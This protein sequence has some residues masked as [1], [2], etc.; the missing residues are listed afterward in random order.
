MRPEA[1]T[2]VPRASWFTDTPQLG[3][4]ASGN[5]A[6]AGGSPDHA[7]PHAGRSLASWGPAQGRE[8]ASPHPLSAL[9]HG[10]RLCHYLPPPTCRDSGGT[11]GESS[12]VKCPDAGQPSA[13]SQA[14]APGG[15]CRHFHGFRERG[16]LLFSGETSE[17]DCWVL[18]I[19]PRMSKKSLTLRPAVS[20]V[21]CS[22]PTLRSRGA[23][24]E[25]AFWAVLIHMGLK[26][27]HSGILTL[28]PTD[29]ALDLG[30]GKIT[31]GLSPVCHLS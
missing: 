8:T 2:R 25:T 28:S 11:R 23:V 22:G 3:E 9:T 13:S 10:Q 19:T 29:L 26:V 30:E 18:V 27:S 5:L 17:D 21:G 7:V 14:K 20:D 4:G 6:A 16:I 12:F 24:A 15:L 31:T 1:R